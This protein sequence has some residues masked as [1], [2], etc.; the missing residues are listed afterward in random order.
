MYK[1]NLVKNTIILTLIQLCLDGLSILLNIFITHELGSSAVGICSLI[2]SFSSFVSVIASGNIFICMSRFASEE[3]GKKNGCPS[4]IFTYSLIVCMI[5]SILTSAG[6]FISAD[7]LGEYF[8]K[9][10]D[11]VIPIRIISLCLPITALNACMKGYFNAYKK[12]VTSATAS[13]V[14]FIAR[15]GIIAFLAEFMVSCGKMNIFSAVSLSIVTGEIISFIFLAFSMHTIHGNKCRIS[16]SGLKFSRYIKMMVPVTLNSYIIVILS[17]IHEALLPLTLKQYEGSTERALSEYGILEAIIMPC[18]YFPSVI[19]TSLAEIIVP[20]I[21]LSRGAEDNKRIE[22][23]TKKI[24]RKTLQ[25]SVY[26]VNIM[27]VCGDELGI[28]LSGGSEF[29]GKMIKTL[30]FVIPFIYLEIILESIIKAV[31]LQKFSSFNYTAEY[32]IRISVLLI[33]VPLMGFYGIVVSYYSSNIISNI[34]RI[35]MIVKTTGISFELFET[36]VVPL[37]ASLISWQT[38]GIVYNMISDEIIKMTAYIVL[39]GIIYFGIIKAS[40]Y[41]KI[42]DGKAIIQGSQ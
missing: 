41:V 8:L 15:S 20:E 35:I 27:L 22:R 13:S 39:S 26:S 25:Y 31:G 7:K 30:A 12:A 32:I 6:V 3:L 2:Y 40:E 42:H 24:I 37:F 33:C 4:V 23:L 14:E 10:S 9:S 16:N 18:I 21:A 36:V 11:M 29:A 17:S 1:S 5:L 38:A 34:S 19:L 28:L